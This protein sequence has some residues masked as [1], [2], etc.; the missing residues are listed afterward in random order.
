ML[1]GNL[2]DLP[3]DGQSVITVRAATSSPRAYVGNYEPPDARD[4]AAYG[5]YARSKPQVLALAPWV[6]P[7]APRA[8]RAARRDVRGAVAR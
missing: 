6:Q 8:P 3:F 2:L 7:A 1:T 5:V 4:P